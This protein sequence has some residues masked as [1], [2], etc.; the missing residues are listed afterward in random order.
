MKNLIYNIAIG[1]V[2]AGLA[3]SQAGAQPSGA[4]FL[5]VD[6]SPR[7]YALGSG[8]PVATAGA[9]SI[10]SNPAGLGRIDHRFEFFSA[11]SS[12]MDGVQ[13]GYGAF[14]INRALDKKTRIQGLGFSFTNLRVGGLEGRDSTGNKSGNNF[15]AQDTSYGMSLSYKLTEKMN[16]GFT[17]KMVQ[18]EI[19]GFTSNRAFGSD[20]GLRY[21]MNRVHRPVAL[22][23]TLANFGQGV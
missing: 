23:L 16:F 4:S 7:S 10:H 6:P 12:M 22:G 19:A 3:L 14:A 5:I 15:G 11:Y 18:S 17:G 13:Y 20:F 2:L 8:N 1:T 9:Q 21:S